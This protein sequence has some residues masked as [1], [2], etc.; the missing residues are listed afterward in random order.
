V[1]LYNLFD[2]KYVRWADV[3]DLA[4]SASGTVDAYT[5]PGRNFT[6]SLTHSF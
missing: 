3:R 2:K 1:G 5:Q 6:I 4:A